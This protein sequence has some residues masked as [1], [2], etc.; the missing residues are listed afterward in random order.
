M[1]SSVRLHC[2]SHMQVFM[3]QG[4]V[5]E[6]NLLHQ[7]SHYTNS[8]PPEDC[9]AFATAGQLDMRNYLSSVLGPSRVHVTTL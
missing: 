4:Q 3:V 5:I 1:D 2:K 9:I 6:S 7:L 8:M